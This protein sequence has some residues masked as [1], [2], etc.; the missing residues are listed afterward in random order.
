M[1]TKPIW[2]RLRMPRFD[3]LKAAQT[4]DVAVVGGGITGL[5]AA[6]LL[7]QAGK[8]VAVLER[9]R[10]GGVDT[11]HTSAHLTY[12]TDLRLRPLAKTFGKQ[13]ARLAWQGGAAAINTIAQIAAREEIDCDFRRLPAYLHAPLDGESDA[14]EFQ[15]EA[16]LAAELNF[17]AEF[18]PGVPFFGKPGIRFPDQ[19]RFHPL[20]YLAGLAKAIEGDGCRIFERTDVAEISDDLT[21]TTADGR[22]VACA[23][24]II[25]T[26]VPL[27]GKSSLA[28]ATLLQ[29][30]L[31]SYS[32][33]V[34]GARAPRGAV[35]EAL[36]WDTS[37]P[38]YYLRVD[39]QERYDYLIFGGE[40]RKTGQ[41]ADGKAPFKELERRLRRLVPSAK[42]TDRWSGQVVETNDGLPF[43]GEAAE[44][45]FAATGFAGNGLTFGTLAAMM[46]CDAVLGRENPWQSLF[47]PQRK[48]IR[49][50]AWEYLKENLDF[51]YYLV[52]DR[53]SQPDGTS[54][55]SVRPGEAKI[56]RL[57]GRR[58]ACSRDRKGKLAKVSAVCTHMGCLVRWNRAERTWDCP[59]HGSR[60]QADGKVIAGP[61]ETPL[62]SVSSRKR[63]RAVR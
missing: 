13:G 11:G 28:S 27:I 47:R 15:R 55:R 40:D 31:A 35:P 6:Y 7:K 39:R 5:S 4:Y 33:Y 59:C 60:F 9:D 32:A 25:A 61:A 52:R 57:D 37:D 21:V 45:Q 24:V 17:P 50:G 22:R 20:A 42:I 49:G 56:L 23:Y 54:T 30:K 44:G 10:I 36:Y 26:H 48:K 1:N 19:A 63:S 43:I 14:D 2:Q 46:A 18:Q 53:L 29:S 58:A 51:P 16:R 3:K 62:E 12:V 34:I 8:R 38:Y 41:A